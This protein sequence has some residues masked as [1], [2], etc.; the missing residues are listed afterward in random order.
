MSS[1]IK[2]IKMMKT[3]FVGATETNP[4]AV[5][6]QFTSTKMTSSVPIY[7]NSNQYIYADGQYIS[8]NMNDGNDKGTL[9]AT[10]LK[11]NNYDVLRTSQVISSDPDA[12][13]LTCPTINTNYLNITDNPNLTIDSSGGVINAKSILIDGQAINTTTNTTTASSSVFDGDNFRYDSQTQTLIFRK[14][15]VLESIDCP[16]INAKDTSI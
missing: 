5:T 3:G 11:C 6:T 8:F 1:D 16:S 15:K 12:G 9:N 14:I 13:T 2:T 4:S 7:Y 10:K